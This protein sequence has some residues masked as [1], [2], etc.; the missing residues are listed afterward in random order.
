MK[1]ITVEEYLTK[2]GREYPKADTDGGVTGAAFEEAGVP[3]V[4]KC[5]HCEM[6]MVTSR[7]RKVDGETGAVFCDE[8]AGY[9]E[10]S[11][12]K[13]EK[14]TCP[15]HGEQSVTG[16][17]STRGADPYGVTY[18]KC[19]CAVI[20]MGP[21]ESNTVLKGLP[22]VHLKRVAFRRAPYN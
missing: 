21:G 12:E 22:S 1:L 19:G 13:S 15:D 20:C 11:E 2:N 14:D 7:D 10:E 17:G 4:V 16:H 9:V 18:L 6:T 8:C 5:T 3:M